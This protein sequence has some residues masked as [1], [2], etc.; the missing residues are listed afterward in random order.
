[1]K[2]AAIDIQKLKWPHIEFDDKA[3]SFTCV[4]CQ[5]TLQLDSRLITKLHSDGAISVI[6]HIVNTQVVPWVEEHRFCGEV[7]AFAV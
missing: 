3:Y 4:T 7:K 5:E 6:Q 1:M 2:S